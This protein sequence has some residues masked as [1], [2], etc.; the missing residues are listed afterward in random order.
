MKDK[1]EQISLLE[2]DNHQLQEENTQL[3]QTR[4]SLEESLSAKGVELEELRAAAANVDVDLQSKYDDAMGKY[5]VLSA[6]HSIA[7]E[8]QAELGSSLE[9]HKAMLET[10][11][12]VWPSAFALV[13][14]ARA[15]P[16]HAAATRRCSRSSSPTF[17]TTIINS[18]SC[19][20]GL[21]HAALLTGS[22]SCFH[23]VILPRR[24]KS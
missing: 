21:R 11:S 24:R 4:A 5:E 9:E 14:G 6:Q 19:E 18:T 13:D 15:A 20:N 1:D 22:I 12:A 16:C 23:P 8:K 7:L 3:A 17:T 2:L 10:A